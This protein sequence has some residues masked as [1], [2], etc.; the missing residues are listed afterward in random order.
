MMSWE[1]MKRVMPHFFNLSIA[2]HND[3]AASKEW[4]WVQ[5]GAVDWY[6]LLKW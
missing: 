4:G 2:V 6:Y 5:V 1:D 3:A